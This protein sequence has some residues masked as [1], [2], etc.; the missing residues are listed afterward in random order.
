MVSVR[1]WPHTLELVLAM[2]HLQVGWTGVPH[3]MRLLAGR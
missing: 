3:T 2:G 1:V